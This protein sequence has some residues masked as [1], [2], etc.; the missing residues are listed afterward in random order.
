MILI[1]INPY[2]VQKQYFSIGDLE[3]LSGIKAHTIRMWER[4]YGMIKPE[5]TDTNIRFYHENELL[6]LLNISI[7]KQSGYRISK[8]AGLSNDELRKCVIESSI[9]SGD[10]EIIIEALIVS[11]LSF[12]ENKFLEV[13]NGSIEK[14]GTEDTFEEVEIPL[15]KRLGLLCDE[16]TINEVQRS[17]IF[18]LIRQKL[19]VAIDKIKSDNIIS[20]DKRIVFFMPKAEWSEIILLFYSLLARKAGFD[21]LYLGPSIPM[22]SLRSTNSIR[23]EDILFLSVDSTCSDQELIKEIVPFLNDNYSEILKLISGMNIKNKVKQVSEK[24]NNAKM[25]CSSK[26]FNTIL[27]EIKE[28]KITSSGC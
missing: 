6:K 1:L 23:K 18:N 4:R 25:V 12:D 17:F 7:L 10:P 15:V 20:V 24:L 8:I 2:F 22:E 27:T 13:L 26:T 9:K 28:N 14:L 16:K 19:I 5:R 21:V 11:M 3:R